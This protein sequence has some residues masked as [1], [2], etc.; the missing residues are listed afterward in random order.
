M[1][2]EKEEF[3]FSDLNKFMDKNSKY[4]GLLSD[5]A[6]VSEITD[7]ISTG[8]YLL[9]AAFT[10]SLFKGI[11]N[12]RSIELCGPSGTGKSYLSLNII[13][14]AQK[15][16]YFVIFYDSE[17]AVDSKLC[18]SF[19]VDLSKLR[20][21]PVQT[22]QEFRTS[23]TQVVDTLIEAKD[24]GKSIPKLFIVLDSIGNLATQKEISDAIAGAEKQDMSRAKV[25][26][27]IFRILMSK[28]GIIGGTFLFTNHIYL[29]QDLFAQQVAGGGTGAE[30]GASAIMFLN[31]AKLK[32]GG[33]EQT[34]IIVTAKPNKNRF[35]KPN[36]VRFHISYNHGMNPYVGL[37]NYLDWN[38]CGVG[39]G[40]F[41]DEKEYNKLSDKD[42]EAIGVCTGKDGNTYYFQ[43]SDTGRNICTDSGEAFSLKQLYTPQVWTEE[44]LRRLD[45][46][47]IKADFAYS[48][49]DTKTVAEE[50]LDE[51]DN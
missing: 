41:I 50:M 9:N 18:E 29:T 5:G 17:N 19:G 10:G 4:G 14:E 38:A 6:G 15:K 46:T 48:T 31:K 37:E 8:N 49:S 24:A 11:P 3:S 43:Q 2:K 12:N 45:E 33:A 47:R 21:E 22:V 30:Y 44:R 13:R 26:K 39:R 40:K 32:E 36:T 27:S 7:Y 35:A 42:K 16:D 25:I 23:V 51:E 34:G 1:A 28:L 20:Y